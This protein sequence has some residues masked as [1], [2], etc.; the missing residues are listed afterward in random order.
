MTITQLKNF[1]KTRADNGLSAKDAKDLVKLAAGADKKLSAAE[2]AQLKTVTKPYSDKFSTAGAKA[3]EEL[4]G[5]VVKPVSGDVGAI[6]AGWK[7]LEGAEA[8]KA[9]KELSDNGDALSFRTRGGKE[10]GIDAD[11]FGALAKS[12]DIAVLKNP[13]AMRGDP[14]DDTGKPG[15]WYPDYHL[16]IAPN[17]GLAPVASQLEKLVS[18]G[19]AADKAVNAQ[20]EKFQGLIHASRVN[21]LGG[22]PD[23]MKIKAEIH[24]AQPAMKQALADFEVAHA[25]WAKQAAQLKAAPLSAEE[26]KLVASIIAS[27]EP[28]GAGIGLSVANAGQVLKAQAL[29]LDR[30]EIMSI[31]SFGSLRVDVLVPTLVKNGGTYEGY[32][33]KLAAEVKAAGITLEVEPDPHR[34]LDQLMSQVLHDVL[35]P[36]LGKDF[37]DGWGST[38]SDGDRDA[39]LT[40]SVKSGGLAKAKSLLPK[41]LEAMKPY[42]FET[43]TKHISFEV[44]DR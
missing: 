30:P 13:K 41:I 36:A 19:A 14:D 11:D 15:P 29:L 5:L 18:T 28:K 25:N 43:L 38:N 6:P 34:H 44:D 42:C 9:F 10:L 20:L 21:E 39:A 3:L 2:K 35:K 17:G 22:P 1:L 31:D 8:V 24:A 40:F 26:K 23:L 16:V 7:K 12:G 27:S 32:E 33:K 4:T 37:V